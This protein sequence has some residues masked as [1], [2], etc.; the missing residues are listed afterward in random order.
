MSGFGNKNVRSF[1]LFVPILALKRY[2]WGRNPNLQAEVY[3]TCFFRIAV[4]LLEVHRL[5]NYPNKA[6]SDYVYAK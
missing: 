2:C 3:P 4:F 5:Q 1:A 6:H